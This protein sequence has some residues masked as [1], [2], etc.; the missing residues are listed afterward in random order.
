M[1]RGYLSFDEEPEDIYVPRRPPRGKTAAPFYMADPDEVLGEHEEDLDVEQ[2]IGPWAGN[3]HGTNNPPNRAAVSFS[4]EMMDYDRDRPLRRPTDP[5]TSGSDKVVGTP[6]ILPVLRPR[7]PPPTMIAG[8]SVPDGH[9]DVARHTEP[10]R[11]ARLV[12]PT[13]ITTPNVTSSSESHQTYKTPRIS[14]YENTSSTSNNYDDADSAPTFI[15]SRRQTHAQHSVAIH[16]EQDAEDVPVTKRRQSK[17]WGAPTSPYLSAS[18]A[19]PGIMGNSSRPRLPVH[20]VSTASHQHHHGEESVQIKTKSHRPLPNQANPLYTPMDANHP[21]MVRKR[22]PIKR[23]E[24]VEPEYEINPNPTPHVPV[25]K[26]R[27]KTTPTVSASPYHIPT[28]SDHSIVLARVKNTIATA[29]SSSILGKDDAPSIESFHK[30]SPLSIN[31]TSGT[32]SSILGKDDAPSIESF[33]KPSPLS[34]NNT[35]GTSSSM[36]DSAPVITTHSATIHPL[37]IFTSSE[38][39]DHHHGC[40]N[41]SHNHHKPPATPHQQQSTPVPE[42]RDSTT[43]PTTRVRAKP[44]PEQQSS[45]IGQEDGENV[46]TTRKGRVLEFSGGEDVDIT[47][48]SAPSI[49]TTSQ[50]RPKPHES[51]S[52]QA[53]EGDEDMRTPSARSNRVG[54]REEAHSGATTIPSREKI[55][56]TTRRRKPLETEDLVS[57]SEQTKSSSE[58]MPTTERKPRKNTL[59]LGSDD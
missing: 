38:S 30:P 39:I 5:I 57:H 16:Q 54:R 1:Q 58:Q 7:N 26:Y 45:H 49:P 35:S 18:D 44:K 50:R 33:H 2:R 17:P 36:D 27:P 46:P 23:Y 19:P 8:S 59:Q 15:L 32:S 10:M 56:P 31:N 53:G 34:I 28:D 6:V 4:E 41:P 14:N 11:R 43:R 42:T 51:H 20:N 52:S 12:Q 29:T 55:P 25:T 24:Q 9:R 3:P 22:V 40:T 21:T 48:D 47:A 37:P 13:I